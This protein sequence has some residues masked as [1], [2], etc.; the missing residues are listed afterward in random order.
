MRGQPLPPGLF[1]V[2]L[3]PYNSDGSIDFA[4]LK[5]LTH[6]YIASGAKGLFTVAQS[7][8]MHQMTP[9]ERLATAKCVLEAAAGRVPVVASGSFPPLGPG[10]AGIEEQAA[11]VNAMWATGVT[12]VV[13]LS[14]AMAQK[15]EDD[16]VFRSNVTRLLELTPGVTLGQYE[17]PAPYH[18]VC[19]APTLAWLAKT[20]RFSF[21]KDTSRHN[22]LISE[23][24]AA[25]RA[26]GLPAVNP[27]RFYNG[28]VTT[29][30][31]SLREGG[32]G[33]GVVCANFYPHI[34]AWLCA[35]FAT[36][37]PALVDQVHAFLAVADAAVKVNYPASAKTYLKEVLG[38]SIATNLARDGAPFPPAGEAPGDELRLR[39]QSMRDLA[40]TL[41]AECGVAPVAANVN[42]RACKRGRSQRSVL[43]P[44]GGEMPLIGLGTWQ[45]PKGEV[46]AAVTAALAANYR[47]IDCAAIY[48][49][50]AEVGEALSAAI[51]GGL[52]RDELFVTSKLWNSEH[53]PKDVRGACVQSLK[54]LKLDYLDLYLIHWPQQFEKVTGSTAQIPRNDDGSVRYARVPLSETWA[55]LEKLVDEGLVRAIGVSNFSIPQMQSV[56]K[57]ARIRPACNQVESHPFFAQDA[58]LRACQELGVLLTAYSP[59]GS[60]GNPAQIG[61]SADGYTVPTH[62]TLMQIGKAHGKSA[63][64]VAL[65]WQ[66]S[67]GVPTFPKSTNAA[68]LA[69]NIDIDDLALSPEEVEA[70][71]QLDHGWLGRGCYGGP[72]VERSG[73]VEPRDLAHADYP[74]M[75]D[76]S[77]RA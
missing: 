47:H 27:F 37:D 25:L 60:P 45:A 46:G 72:K 38:L 28:N 55:A 43:L 26:A 68:R 49:N 48:G 30:L 69:Q 19:S 50:E 39:L 44:S 4:G 11:S 12:A 42:P 75:P 21:H 51:G 9:E 33:A 10:G 73:V 7:S 32:A 77:E 70:I 1:P 22:P 20:G 56:C 54:D 63:A 36:A 17:C 29:L 16:S 2:M 35:N 62:P 5:T 15:D 67:R 23:K 76:G 71:N 13:M 24:L 57:V 64:Q 61:T 53:D 65:A 14:C 40:D 18:R 31:H 6:W 58:L 41:S 8:E 3:T 52:K 59:L 74:W 34:V 66:I